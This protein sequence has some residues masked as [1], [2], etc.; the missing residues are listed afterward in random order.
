MATSLTKISR[1]KSGISKTLTSLITLP[2]RNPFSP[3]EG[4]L[5]QLH[6]QRPAIHHQIGL[7]GVDHRHSLVGGLNHIAFLD[8]L[9]ARKLDALFPGD[10]V[11]TSA[12]VDQ[13]AVRQ[14]HGTRQA[15][16]VQ[17]L[18][19]AT[20][21]DGHALWS[22]VIAI[23]ISCAKLRMVIFPSLSFL[24]SPAASPYSQGMD[25]MAI[26]NQHWLGQVG[27]DGTRLL[28]GSRLS[29]PAALD[30]NKSDG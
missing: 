16:G 14:T 9:H 1:S 5:H 7:V 30:T 24:P 13:D 21:D 11:E 23:A 2:M 19:L 10:V 15:H 8:D 27:Q 4:C 29:S 22:T 26:Q 18:S 12:I 28:M 17:G 6:R 3:I 25:E 20:T